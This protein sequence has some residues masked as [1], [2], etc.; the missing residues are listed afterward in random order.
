MVVIWYWWLKEGDG[1]GSV[2]GYVLIRLDMAVEKFLSDVE[3]EKGWLA[4]DIM[5]VVRM[6]ATCGLREVNEVACIE[7]PGKRRWEGMIKLS[8]CIRVPRKMLRL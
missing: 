8:Y 6:S 7:T 4:S 3:G 1:R 5:L 2:D